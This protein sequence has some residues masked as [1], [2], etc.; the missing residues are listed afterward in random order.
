M[1]TLTLTKLAI[2]LCAVCASSQL[3]AQDDNDYQRDR[4]AMTDDRSKLRGTTLHQEDAS[5]AQP[6]AAQT[7]ATQTAQPAAQPAPQTQVVQNNAAQQVSNAAQVPAQTAQS[8]AQQ[9]TTQIH[10]PAPV[11]KPNATS[12]GNAHRQASSGDAPLTAGTMLTALFKQAQFWHDK[13]QLNL[14]RQSL[15]RVLLADPDNADALYLLSLWSMENAEVSEAERWKKR[16]AEAAPHDPRLQDLNNMADLSNLSK[17]QLK[18]AREMAASGNIPG[19]VSNYQQLFKN[20]LPP[21]ALVSEYYLTLSGDPARYPEAVNG[22][23]Q[24]IRANPNDTS[25]KITYGKLLSYR[26]ETRRQGIEVLQYFA[27]SSP[28][29]DSALREALLWLTPTPADEKYYVDYA[30]RHP[31]DVDVIGHYSNNM[32]GTMTSKAYEEVKNKNEQSARESFQ[33]ILARDPNNVNAL[34]GLGYLYMRQQHYKEASEYLS[35]AAEIDSPKKQKLHYDALLAS[36]HQAEADGDLNLAQTL[37]DE[38]LSMNM[39]D[40][41]D[42]ML[43]KANLYRKTR[44]YTRAEELLRQILAD[45]P[46][47]QG[48]QENLYYTLLDDK[49][50]EEAKALLTTFSPTLQKTIASR[51]GPAYVDPSIAIRKSAAQAASSGNTARALDILYQGLQKHPN[52]AWIRYDLAALLYR[53]GD[54]QSAMRELAYLT[55]QGASNESLYAAA[56]LQSVWGDASGALATSQRISSSYNNNQVRQLRANIKLRS[57][58]DKAE[59]YVRQGQLPAALNTLRT[60]NSR[61][62]SLE[63]SDLGHL[64]Y[65]YLQ[66]GDRQ[67]AVQLADRAVSRGVKPNATVGDFADVI[68]VFNATGNYD[69]ARYLTE[70]HVLVANS[71]RADLN[72]INQGKYIQEA[73]NLRKYGRY[74]DAYDLLYSQMLQNPN[75]PD[76]MMAMARLY[77]DNNDFREE[78]KIYDRVLYTEPNNQAAL[79][80]AAYAALANKHYEKAEALAQNIVGNDPQTLLLKAQVARQNRKYSDAID[81]LRMSKQMLEGTLS[82]TADPTLSHAGN[83]SPNNPFRNKH[84]TVAPNRVNPSVMPWEKMPDG[85][86]YA[87]PVFAQADNGPH[88]DETLNEVNRM[89]KELYEI[90]S[91][92]VKAQLNANQKKGEAGL[93]EVNGFNA[94]I[95]MSFPLAGEHRLTA[96]VTPTLM[97]AGTPTADSNMKMGTNALAVGATSV[98]T[99]VNAMVG[100]I[101]YRYENRYTTTTEVVDGKTV[102]TKVDNWAS[103]VAALE[104]EYGIDSGTINALVTGNYLNAGDYNLTS[105][106]DVSRLKAKLKDVY[107]ITKTDTMRKVMA[108]TGTS[109]KNLGGAHRV[110]EDGIE[111]SLTLSGRSYKADIGVTPI[112]KRGTTFV[113]GWNFRPRIGKNTELRVNVERRAVRDSVLSYYGLK[114]NYSGRFWGAVTKN[115]GSI[116]L[117]YDNGYFG[118]YG[119]PAYYY[120]TGENVDDNHMF[121][122]NTG[123]YARV[124]NQQTQKLTVGLDINYM[125]FQKNQNRFSMGYGGYFSPQDYYSIAIPVNYSKQWE[126]LNLEAS[127]SIGYQSFSAKGGEY[128]PKD[129]LW[130]ETLEELYNYGL[131]SAT[132][133]DNNDKSGISGSV[134]VKLDYDVNDAFKVGGSFNY[135]TFGDYKE[136]SEMLYFKYLMGVL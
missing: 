32:L 24:Y 87:S 26:D 69:K 77:H 50:P 67:T 47:N 49:K 28:D 116:Q 17:D 76:L 130:Q 70:H 38:M 103:I 12:Q 117:A 71:N 2:C 112:G 51:Q 126:N 57:D 11:P 13:Q 131:V 75:D 5:A 36:A 66:A 15:N 37:T 114:D 64:A 104:S 29:S 25:A 93:S 129:K 88:N 3:L 18:R 98:V 34:E 79:Q 123:A 42:I 61:S 55:R 99:A 133:Y 110:R 19:A 108:A 68:S 115:G 109:N 96:T 14:A 43:F 80:G 95:S 107:G 4:A 56:T 128:F 125:N 21:R 46:S 135:N 40:P 48:A 127:A 72:R 102:V 30:R 94:P 53:N 63:T 52:S 100:D 8:Q 136:Y 31:Q 81:Y 74:A 122:F 27:D 1:K 82:P 97:D 124:I 85:Q 62:Q 59:Q 6:A 73:D 89:L 35:K 84:S 78:E 60:I 90:T 20:G 118:V 44:Q 121:G 23:A 105:T 65:L 92:H 120:Y 86:T 134:N 101:K 83:Y 39:E 7:T 58:M 45:H 132:R 41:T 54:K 113:G 22:I 16:L 9:S 91:I 33:E 106:S 119:G 10:A 111:G